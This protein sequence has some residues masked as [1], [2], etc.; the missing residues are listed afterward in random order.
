MKQSKFLN[1][2]FLFKISPKFTHFLT[3]NII[4]YYVISAKVFKNEINT[5]DRQ[6]VKLCDD[7]SK[8]INLA[9]V[10][11][12]YFSQKCVHASL[13]YENRKGVHVYRSS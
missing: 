4:A 7:T 8:Y 6:I 10:E 12:L 13:Y 3:K 5:L 11:F 1:F 2:Q 9:F